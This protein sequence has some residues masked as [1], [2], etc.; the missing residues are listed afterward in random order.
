[1]S[2]EAARERDAWI[3]AQLVLALQEVRPLLADR[4]APWNWIAGIHVLDRMEQSMTRGEDATAR[5]IAA[6]P[7]RW[8]PAQRALAATWRTMSV[9]RRLGVDAATTRAASH[10]SLAMACAGLGQGPGLAASDAAAP[11]LTRMIA[12][13]Q[14]ESDDFPRHRVRVC[15][16]LHALARAQSDQE[17]AVGVRPLFALVQE[18]ERWRQPAGMDGQRSETELLQWTLA[19]ASPRFDAKWVRAVVA[20]PA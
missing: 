15:A 3:V 4:E 16:I 5:A 17:R 8:D 18:M 20:G 7:P 2:A 14:G 1:M 6:M 12:R 19:Q 9:L 13:R 10:A 11:A